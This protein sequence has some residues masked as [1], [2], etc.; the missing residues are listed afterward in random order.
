MKRLLVLVFVGSV[1]ASL[2]GC[3]S[4][5]S[6]EPS[7]RP[8]DST[9]ATAKTN[10]RVD[11]LIVGLADSA[12]RVDTSGGTSAATDGF[13][14]AFGS[15]SCPAPAGS[16]SS[17]DD[18]TATITQG[19]DDFLHRLAEEAREHVFREDRVEV[20]DGNQVVY[21][22]D[23][24]SACG[25]SVECLEKLTANPLRFAV[26]ASADDTLNIALMVG[27][28]RLSPAS[29]VLGPSK[30]SVRGDLAKGLE[31]VRLFVDAADQA[32]LPERLV[33]V[34]EGG[35]EKRAPGDFAITSSL[36]EKFDLL[37]GQ[38]KGKPVAVTVQP[39]VPTAKLTLNSITNTV[40]YSLAVGAADVQVAGTAVCNSDCG[41]RE[42]NGSFS[43]HVGGLRG[44][45]TVSKG[46]TEVTLTGLG[47]GNDTAYVALDGDRLG[48]LDVNANQGRSL[49]LTFKKTTEG[50][51]V[52]FEPA[53]DIK[54]ALMLNKLSESLRVDMPDWLS[55]EIFEV[56]LGG[57]AK[58]SVLIPAPVCDAYGNA[59][60]KDE[61]QVASGT[62]TLSASSLAS[63]VEVTA[64]MCLLPVDGADS[65]ANPVSQVRSGAC[66]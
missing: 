4:N 1:G 54:L 40:G 10:Q 28:A 59:T 62:L 17:T 56:M 19:L 55:N 65:N 46:A 26:T 42:K 18:G 61:L 45:F 9:E 20:R 16:A 44:A 49:S 6:S 60:S 11:E 21:K 51:L 27:D 36:V 24:A 64:G 63:P 52:T 48:T 7:P 38:G 5:T 30:L 53:L 47:L 14:G 57:A 33:G 22:I 43:G 37:V 29:A 34:F 66:K 25:D 2:A 23:P 31:A 50:T 41:S 15:S 12:S 58:P 13:Q 35:L 8:L 39:S 3:G 32:D